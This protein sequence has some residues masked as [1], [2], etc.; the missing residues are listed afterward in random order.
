MPGKKYKSAKSLFDTKK[1]YSIEEAVGLAKKTSITKFDSS[2]DVAIK[3]NLDT[4]KAEQQLRGTIALPHYFGKT[5]RVLLI[6]SDVTD[7]QAKEAG[8]DYFG[9]SDKIADIKNGWL[10]FD[11]I[12]TT[13]K[14]MPELSKL[15]KILGPKGLMPNPKL[16]TV[17]PKPLDAVKEFKK[18]KMNYR[19]DTYGNIHMTIGKVSAAAEKVIENFNTLLDFIKSKR[20]STVKGEYIQKI[21]LSTTMGPAIKVQF[22]K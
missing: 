9:G 19:T 21:Y 18:G 15:G 4:T 16:G 17:T 2:I 11:V 20:P 8:A 10:D 6:S 5:K 13:P 3:L 1:I 12:I 14:F 7:A 22:D